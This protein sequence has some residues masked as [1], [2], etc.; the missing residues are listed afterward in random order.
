MNGPRNSQPK[1]TPRPSSRLSS[2]PPS[3]SPCPCVLR[4][5]CY[6]EWSA[7]SLAQ[8]C[9]WCHTGLPRVFVLFP[10]PAPLPPLP[11]PRPPASE[12][13]PIKESVWDHPWVPTYRSPLPPQKNEPLQDPLAAF[14]PSCQTAAD[15]WQNLTTKTVKLVPASSTQDPKAP[16]CIYNCPCHL[17]LTIFK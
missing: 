17:G 2:L 12:K 3:P 9:A 1:S 7:F 5:R 15:M 16:Y 14:Q 10:P 11:L 6:T 13:L 8:R 4:T